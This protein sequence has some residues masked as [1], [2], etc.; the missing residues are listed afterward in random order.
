MAEEE[1]R[2]VLGRPVDE[3][4]ESYKAWITGMYQAMTGRE[5]EIDEESLR[6]GWEVFWQKSGKPELR[7]DRAGVI[8]R[9][10]PTPAPARGSYQRSRPGLWRSRRARTITGRRT[11]P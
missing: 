6:R 10:E 8:R 11:N 9:Q 5:A 2:L 1:R 7:R 4:F 3:A